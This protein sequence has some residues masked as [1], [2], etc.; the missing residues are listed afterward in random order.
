MWGLKGLV[1]SKLHRR[2][3][4]AQAVLFH[5]SVANSLRDTTISP[6]SGIWVTPSGVPWPV[7]CFP[8]TENTGTNYGKSWMWPKE[9]RG[10]WTTMIDVKLRQVG[11][12]SL[13]K[14]NLRG[15]LNNVHNGCLHQRIVEKRS[16]R[17]FSGGTQ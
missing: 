8:S 9:G 4:Y 11:L 6:P 3:Q 10:Y 1:D 2:Q 14:E 13:E 7:W 15:D 16:S 5:M 17:H 12:F